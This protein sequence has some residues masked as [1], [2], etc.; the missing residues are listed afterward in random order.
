MQG[1]ERR[2][3][4]D[5]VRG[6]L[7]DSAGSE[8]GKSGAAGAGSGPVRGGRPGG[9]GETVEL[10]QLVLVQPDHRVDRGVDIDS[11]DKHGG[12]LG[13]GVCGVHHRRSRRHSCR[14]R[15][16]VLLSQ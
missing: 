6:N 16:Q 2:A 1:G 4:G 5:S 15:R 9:G 8:W 14:V 11:V 12:G 7:P 13:L 10:F 3:G